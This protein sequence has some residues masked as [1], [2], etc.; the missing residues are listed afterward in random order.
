MIRLNKYL[1]FVDSSPI[2]SLSILTNSLKKNC[3]I[4]ITFDYRR[5]SYE[6]KFVLK[7]T[8]LLLNSLM[9][10]H[11]NF[12]HNITSKSKWRPGPPKV[13]SN[14]GLN[15]TFF[16]QNSLYRIASWQSYKINLVLNKTILVLN[17]LVVKYLY[18]HCNNSVIRS[19]WGNAP[20][21]NLRL[22]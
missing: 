21:T 16:R 3:C 4:I 22:I 6:R 9:L 1:Y 5:M 8:K 12:Y 17:Y 2:C 18:S 11:L 13:S 14:L 10:D 15:Y 7:E 20:S 19:N